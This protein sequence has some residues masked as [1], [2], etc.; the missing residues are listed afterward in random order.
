MFSRSPRQGLRI[1]HIDAEA[2]ALINYF[3]VEAYLEARRRE[4]QASSDE[5][6]E[7][8]NRVALV[9]ARIVGEPPA[10]RPKVLTFRRRRRSR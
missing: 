7:D 6:A 5:I 8:W 1:E 9:V 3:G 2:E 4:R 10:G